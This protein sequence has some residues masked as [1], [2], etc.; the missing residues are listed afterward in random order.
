MVVIDR[1]AEKL[2]RA[3]EFFIPKRGCIGFGGHPAM[4]RQRLR[5]AKALLGSR[6]L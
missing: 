2:P 5:L 4:Q 6:T 3:D 1:N